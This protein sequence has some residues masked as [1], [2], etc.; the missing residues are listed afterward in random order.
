MLSSHGKV[1]D[2][3]IAILATPGGQNL[4]EAV[5]Q[6]LRETFKENGQS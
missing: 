2:F 4:A 5:N 6:R 3:P 1:R